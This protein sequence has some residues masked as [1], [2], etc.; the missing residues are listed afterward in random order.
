RNEVT[1]GDFGAEEHVPRLVEIERKVG[2]TE[3]SATFE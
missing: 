1:Q 2:R 3:Q